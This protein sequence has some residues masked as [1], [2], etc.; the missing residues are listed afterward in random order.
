MIRSNHRL[1]QPHRQLERHSRSMSK[2]ALVTHDGEIVTD[3]KIN[4]PQ[5]EV[6]IET[7]M[8]DICQQAAAEAA[9]VSTK[10]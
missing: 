1:S 2:L 4:P 8:D 5:P 6:G 3:T 10:Q 9:K 7:T